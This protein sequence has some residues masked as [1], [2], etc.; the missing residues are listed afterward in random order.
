MS[1]YLVAFTVGDFSFKET[2]DEGIKYRIVTRPSELNDAQE[3]INYSPWILKHFE[4]YFHIKFPL[5]KLD[6]LAA[7]DFSAGGMENW[8]LIIYREAYLLYNKR[9]GSVVQL[10]RIISVIAHEIAHQWFGK[11]KDQRNS[12]I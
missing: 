1:T 2:I 3:A 10:Y 11:I 5:E 9:I 8:G 4:K 6:M 12:F 7:C